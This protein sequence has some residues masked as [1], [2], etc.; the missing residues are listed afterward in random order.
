[1]SNADKG[2]VGFILAQKLAI[3]TFY[4]NVLCLVMVLVVS[5]IG[6]RPVIVCIDSNWIG[7]R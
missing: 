6:N 1:M 7:H 3:L 2:V 5:A 4:I